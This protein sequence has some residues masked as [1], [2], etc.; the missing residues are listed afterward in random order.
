[1]QQAQDLAVEGDLDVAC[2]LAEWG[3]QAAPESSTAHRVRADVYRR[4]HRSEI[5]LMVK[6]I[7]ED[8]ARNSRPLLDP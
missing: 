6:G 7:F 5:S 1:V 2:Q 3:V 8:A 4:R